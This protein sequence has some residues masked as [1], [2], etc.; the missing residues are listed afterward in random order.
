MSDP[1]RVLITHGRHDTDEFLAQLKADVTVLL[2]AYGPADVVLARD[3]YAANFTR[4]GGWDG[5][6][7]DVASGI[8]PVSREPRYHAYVVPSARVGKATAAILD[9]A[10]RLGKPVFRFTPAKYAGLGGQ[11]SGT[12]AGVRAITC[13]NERDF[14]AGWEVRT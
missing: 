5:W 3:D 12:F 6:S 4:C 2:A 13:V 8:D 7:I 14:K 1:I 10:L 9:R 11:R